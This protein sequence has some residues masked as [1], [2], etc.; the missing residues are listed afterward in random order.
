M[1][2]ESICSSKVTLIF[3]SSGTQVA[4]AAMLIATT[5]GEEVSLVARVVKEK[6]KGAARAVPLM[7]LAPTVILALYMVMGAKSAEGL[8]AAICWQ[9][10]KSLC[11]PRPQ[12]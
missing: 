12:P 8:K 5:F 7:S 6:L 10:R 9:C 1:V 3:W 4:P 2:S 11:P